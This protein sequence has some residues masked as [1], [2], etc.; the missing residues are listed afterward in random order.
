MI[1]IYKIISPSGKIYVG[2]SV[3]INKRW[4][5]YFCLNCKGQ[6]ILYNSLLKYGAENHI[7]EV[8]EE[9]DIEL[10]N[11]KERYYQDLYN[12]VGK[13]GMNCILKETF[14]KAGEISLQTR[15]KMSE[16]AKK[17]T[18]TEEHRN[19]LRENKS[20]KNNGMFGKTHSEETRE[21]MRLLKVNKKLSKEHIQ[22]KI[23]S[24]C[25]PVICTET[26]KIWNSV[27][28]CGRENK[29]PY[30]TLLN[31]LKNIRPNKTTFIWQTT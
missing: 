12:V 2:Q 19:K 5:H 28:E 21:K 23:K 4:N 24:Q 13:F 7:F 3:D 29:I 27:A 1:G 26:N 14:D 6:T 30:T 20:G 25:T 8:I 11:E 22:N 15:I 31:Y 16:S 10:L 9:C 17:K 18:I